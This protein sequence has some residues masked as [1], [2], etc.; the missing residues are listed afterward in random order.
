MCSR[1]CQQ[2]QTAAG[3]SGPGEAEAGHRAW[4]MQGLVMD[5]KKH[6]GAIKECAATENETVLV[7]TAVD[8]DYLNKA[9]LPGGAD[10]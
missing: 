9:E 4:Q 6:K 5:F 2:P 1:L 10:G 3:H 8:E 7:R